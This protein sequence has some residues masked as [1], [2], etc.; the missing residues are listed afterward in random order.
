MGLVY[1]ASL[2]EGDDSLFH[3]AGP[4]ETCLLTGQL[5]GTGGQLLGLEELLDACGQGFDTAVCNDQSGSGLADAVGEIAHG[6]GQDG[7]VVMVGHGEHA[8]LGGGTVGQH[9][10]IGGGEIDRNVGIADVMVVHPD[11]VACRRGGQEP[12]VL[13][14][15]AVAFAGNEQLIAIGQPIHRFDEPV[16]PF[17]VADQSEEEEGLLGGIELQATTRLGAVDLRPEMV[18]Q[19][20]GRELTGSL[21]TELADGLPHQIAQDNETA[22]L[23]EEELQQRA[24]EPASFVGDG[25]VHQSHHP[26]VPLQAVGNVGVGR[27]EEG[28]PVGDDEQI[29]PKTADGRHRPEIADG[30]DAV[31]DPSALQAG[32]LVALLDILR[33]AG[34]EQVGIEPREVERSDGMALLLQFGIE[35]VT[36]LGNASPIGMK[37]GEDGDPTNLLHLMIVC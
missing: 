16:Q 20:M 1:E 14:E 10:G 13:V 4:G 5:T 21:G 6:R 31:Q 23:A 9:E 8:T 36:E 32:R 24:V 25:I 11:A 28:H 37:G 17:V 30:V 35:P 19:G 26:T 29:R 22:T 33:L 2:Q 12:F 7:Q 18:I 27:H 34:E 3:E 15:A